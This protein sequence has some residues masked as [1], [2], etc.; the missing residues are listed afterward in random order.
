MD[1]QKENQAIIPGNSHA[2]IP[3][4]QGSYYESDYLMALCCQL[5]LGMGQ[6]TSARAKQSQQTVTATLPSHSYRDDASQSAK[7]VIS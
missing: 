1:K 7:E 3:A 2:A 5:D 6:F 4:N